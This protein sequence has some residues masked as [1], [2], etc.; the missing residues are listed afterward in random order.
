MVFFSFPLKYL[1][2]K[3]IKFEDYFME[4]VLIPF[5]LEKFILINTLVFL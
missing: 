1:K 3:S 5:Y 2:K 4:N